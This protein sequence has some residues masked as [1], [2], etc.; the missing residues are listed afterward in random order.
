MKKVF[1]ILATLFVIAGIA[2][3]AV[4]FAAADFDFDIFN[5]EKFNVENIDITDSFGKISV[6]AQTCDI[7]FKKSADRLTHVECNLRDG[8]VSDVLVENNTLVINV[9]ESLKV[10]SVSSKSQAITVYLPSEIYDI[11]VSLST[12]DTFIDSLNAGKVTM[13]STTGDVK[14]TSVHCDALETD[15]TTGDVLLKNVTVDGKMSV[16]RSTGDI[17]LDSSDASEIHLTSTTGDISGTVLT[18][19][20]FTAKSSTGDISVPKTSEGGICEI[21]T[22]TGDIKVKIK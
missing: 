4:F 21:K 20:Q 3:A 2:L 12:G 1:L 16:K 8:S 7:Y 19:K 15:G 22:T 14:I 17:K 5:T 11:S 18:E 13:H 10:F 6:N 9:K